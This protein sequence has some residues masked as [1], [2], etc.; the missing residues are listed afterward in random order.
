MLFS[1]E[2][3]V[4]EDDLF[5]FR[6]ELNQLVNAIRI[7]RLTVITGIRR[8]GKTSLMNVALSKVGLP[9]V[10]LDV[11][12]STYP[13]YADLVSLWAKAL[14]DF[15]RRESRLKDR[16][17]NTLRGV[18][19]L[20]ISLNPVKVSVVFR[21]PGK[22]S[23]ADLLIKI[24]ELAEDVGKRVII[25]IDEAQEL[26]RAYWF[27]FDRLL[28]YA[29][30]NLRNVNFVL[31]GSQI[32][33]LYDFL[34][35]HNPK[36]PLFGRAYVEISTRR[37]SPDESHEFLERGFS[38]VGVT[39]GEDAI[40]RAINEFNGIIGWLTYFGYSYAVN[41]IPD[42]DRIKGMAVDL[43]RGELLNLIGNLRSSRYRVVLRILGEGPA[44]WRVI[45]NRLEVIEGRYVSDTVL[46]N[47][48]STLIKM[49][50]I[51]KRNDEYA[52]IDPIYAA[53][54]RTL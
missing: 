30:D 20:S 5:N 32:G 22:L 34:G 18:S 40:M 31:T 23:I 42:F 28:A 26:S 38:Q 49:S 47:L 29:Y 50:I 48:L 12:L 7:S 51:E 44:T 35:I 13:N 9:Y 6:V 17:L 37:L 21:G 2:P 11:R 52:I 46:S 45:K 33:L 19:G 27:R 15:L 54:A 3:K 53:A 1:P 25:A 16:I 43:A 41:G 24:N 10:Y 36:A 14:E 8:S 4:S 39:C